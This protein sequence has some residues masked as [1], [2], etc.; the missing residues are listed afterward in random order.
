MIKMRCNDQ[1]GNLSAQKAPCGQKGEIN[2]E[3]SKK[4]IK[5]KDL[6]KGRQV[7]REEM[8][9]TLGGIVLMQSGRYMNPNFSWG[10]PPYF[11]PIQLPISQ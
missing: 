5:I 7:S 8:R 3:K 2:M 10:Q 11:T 6:P 1:Y 4:R 9:K